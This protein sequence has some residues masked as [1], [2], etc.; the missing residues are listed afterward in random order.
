MFNTKLS[1]KMRQL[2]G[3]VADAVVG[4][5]RVLARN[6]R[7]RSHATSTDLAGGG[8]VLVEVLVAHPLVREVEPRE[9]VGLTADAAAT[10]RLSPVL[11]RKFLQF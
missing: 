9:A 7:R 2:D 11:N 6:G 4:L 8:L 10:A 3:Q 5:A 1:F